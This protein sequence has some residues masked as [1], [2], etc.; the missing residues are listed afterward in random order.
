VSLQAASILV[1]AGVLLWVFRLEL[2]HAG[3]LLV[4]KVFADDGDQAPAKRRGPTYQE[5]MLD[6]ADVRLRLVETSSLSKDANEA[7]ETLTLALLA[8]SDK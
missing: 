6:L 7:V 4:G 2:L 3:E 1:A 5:A 8:G